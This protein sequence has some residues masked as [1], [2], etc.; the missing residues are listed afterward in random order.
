M[1]QPD[2]LAD[3]LAPAAPVAPVQDPFSL[4]ALI[5]WLRTKR[6]T[7][8]WYSIKSCLICQ[9][10]DHIGIMYSSVGASDYVPEPWTGSRKQLPAFFESIACHGRYTFPEALRRAL[11]IKA[12][13]S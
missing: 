7:Y 4:D 11:A 13:Q 3:L 12:R 9:Y 5:A 2:K 10:L 1:F 8:D 6:G